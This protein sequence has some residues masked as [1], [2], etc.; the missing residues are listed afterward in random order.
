M[1]P[2]AG[3]PDR[4]FRS[5]YRSRHLR[6]WRPSAASR[7]P[8]PGKGVVH[9]LTSAKTVQSKAASG[10]RRS[11]ACRSSACTLHASA[12]TRQAP[13][14]TGDASISMRASVRRV[15]G[16]NGTKSSVCTAVASNPRSHAASMNARS[17]GSRFASLE[18]KR[19]SGCNARHGHFRAPDDRLAQSMTLPRSMHDTSSSSASTWR[20]SMT[21][22]RSHHRLKKSSHSTSVHH[23]ASSPLQVSP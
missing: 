6:A 13:F 4:G 11:V 8:M 14:I 19:L 7:A 17:I 1:V 20:S 16:E 18:A 3:L 2:A 10:M 12:T 22:R 21:V 9:G 5:G 15:S 23:S